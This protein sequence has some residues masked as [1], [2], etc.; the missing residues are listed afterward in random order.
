[1]VIGGPEVQSIAL[2]VAVGVE[3]VEGMFLE[4]HGASTPA[5]IGFAVERARSAQLGR[6]AFE[7]VEQVEVAED[8][9]DGDLLTQ[10]A[11]VNDRSCGRSSFRFWAPRFDRCRF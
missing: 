7:S 11:E 9:F 1:M 2:R 3:T 10:K 5:R 6:V 4:M 8:L